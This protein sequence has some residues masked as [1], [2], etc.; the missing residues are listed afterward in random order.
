MKVVGQ[1]LPRYYA[2][3]HVTAGTRYVDDVRVPGT[4]WAKALRSPHHNAEI[5]AIDTSKA[6]AMEGV[7]AVITHQDVHKNVHGHIEGLGVPGD[8]PL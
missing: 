1:R 2:G 5:V 4:L 6:E 7:F 3:A 8:E